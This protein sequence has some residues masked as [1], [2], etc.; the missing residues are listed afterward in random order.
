MLGAEGPSVRIESQRLHL[1]LGRPSVD[2]DITLCILAW[3]IILLLCLLLYHTRMLIQRLKKNG[4]LKIQ[5]SSL[6]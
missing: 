5:A 4:G 1:A 3:L 2:K 6:V